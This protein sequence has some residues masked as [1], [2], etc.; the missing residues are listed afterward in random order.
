MARK[1][2]ISSISK[3]V[4]TLLVLLIAATSM[5]SAATA[6]AVFSSPEVPT[7][8]STQGAASSLD[9][10]LAQNSPATDDK[11]AWLQW[12]AVGEASLSW[13]WFDIYHSQLRT[14]S[15]EYQGITAPLALQIRYQRNIAAEELLDATAE[16]WQ[17]LG[18]HNDDIR[19]WRQH[20]TAIF[21]TVAYGD[22]LVFVS[23]GRQGRFYFYSH[24]EAQSKGATA[25]SYR[26]LGAIHQ[27]QLNRAFLAIWLAENSQYPQL[28]QQL[29]G[30]S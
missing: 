7:D 3:S 17:K 18:Y 13:L 12:P 21:P 28:R 29:I 5:I 1:C 4:T 16:Q 10:E 11:L 9:K 27:P 15:G 26:L 23:N 22:Q 6:N 30:A 20:L 25:A 2:S 24:N 14:P 19:L 8:M